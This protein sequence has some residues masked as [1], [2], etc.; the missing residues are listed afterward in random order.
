MVDLNK[1]H[2][3]FDTS[4]NQYVIKVYSRKGGKVFIRTL[5]ALHESDFSDKVLILVNNPRDINIAKEKILKLAIEY[6][7][8]DIEV[9]NYFNL[10]INKCKYRFAVRDN[11]NFSK[12]DYPV[13]SI[14]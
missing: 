10:N 12:I 11:V 2:E 3:H 5:L 9:I 14:V 7:N 4:D 13:F 8:Y 1:I 6:F